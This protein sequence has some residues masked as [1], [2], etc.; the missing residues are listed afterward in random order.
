[1]LIVDTLEQGVREGLVPGAAAI[2]TGPQGTLVQAAA[3]VAA[4]AVPMRTDTVFRIASMTKPIT[5]LAVLM[6]VEE[7]RLTLDD[8]L[9]AH[10]P[11]FAQPGVLVAYDETTRQYR[12]REA[13]RPVLIRDLLS[14][15]SGYGY[16]FLD[17][18]L[19]LESEGQFLS[20]PFLMHDPG[21]RFSY[22]IGTDILGLVFEPVTGLPLERFFAER[23]TGPLGL[24][25][26]RFKAPDDPA[27]AAAV[28]RRDGGGFVPVPGTPQPDAPRGGGGL[29]STLA[30]YAALMRFMLNRGVTDTGQRL[31]DEA[32]LDTMTTNRI[33]DLF[34]ETPRSAYPPRT[35]DFSFIDGTQKFGFNLLLET[36]PRPQGRH[37]GSYGWAGICNTFFWVDPAARIGAALMMQVSPFCDA[38]CLQLLRRFERAVYS[39]SSSSAASVATAAP[40]PAA[41]R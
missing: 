10:L 11:G 35:L 41:A 1:M 5:T 20:A 29:H 27:R 8:P 36:L 18:P 39:S 37:A 13:S 26:T 2:V 32:L 19:L 30:D 16:W 22:G 21:A 14:H 12:V 9:A 3:G 38:G 34:V 23:V 28:L 24:R 40:A 4:P 17:R 31:L 7:G 15:T 33:G 25:D 6:L